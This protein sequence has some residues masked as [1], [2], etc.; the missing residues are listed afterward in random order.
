MPPRRAGPT[1]LPRLPLARKT[2][3]PRSPATHGSLQRAM[4]TSAGS[5]ARRL[6][7]FINEAWTPYHA[8]DEAK[9]RLLKAGYVQ[10]SERDAWDLQ[11]GG[12]YFFTRNM[13]TLVAF[14]VGGQY[15]AGNG[16]LVVGAHTDSPCL[17]LKPKTARTREGYLQ[18]A[19]QTYGGGLWHT[20]FDRDLGLAGRVL[21]RR[22]AALSPELVKIDR[23]ILR[24]PMLAIHLNRDIYTAG[25]KPNHETELAPVLATEV[26]GKLA[27]AAGAAKD[28]AGEWTDAQC[29]LLLSLLADELGCA[30]GDIVDF[31]L[32]LCDVQPGS[33]GGA[34][35]EFLFVGRLDNLASSF[36]ALEALLDAEGLAAEGSVRAVALFDHE[37][38]GSVSAV[39]AGGSV[40]L[41]TIRRAAG[42]MAE[43]AEG[44][45]ERAMQASFVVSADMAHAVHP[46]Y[47]DR[48]EPG[49]KPMMHRGVVI[50]HNCNQRYATSSV[51]AALFREIGA[52]RGLPC[53]E[54]VV[55]QDTGCGSTI[56]P[57]IS[58]STGIRTVDVGVAQLSMHSIREMCGTDDIDLSKRH[59][60]AF[61]E[62]FTQLDA[63]VQV[64]NLPPAD[65]KGTISEPDC[66]ELGNNR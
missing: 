57:V 20:W 19:V 47:A 2:L 54:F 55:R 42:A 61:F 23:P 63:T 8:V 52:R 34:K 50:K 39:G 65:I 51:T 56:G 45:V 26:K 7:D 38:V 27:A 11:P 15:K 66:G 1:C 13:S 6:L 62:D 46:N 33:V 60:Q 44:A 36:T 14:A 12:K 9:R 53:Q 18:L 41:D 22:G 31:D 30:P 21:V 4:A 58:A 64:D 5:T 25:F 59:F 37:E 24:V 3:R 32:N 16:F 40:M 48:H 35:E 28:A 29:P 43:G 10:I 17:K 49:H